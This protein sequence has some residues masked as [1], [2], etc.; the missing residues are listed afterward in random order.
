MHYLEVDFR[1]TPACHFCCICSASSSRLIN[2]AFWS[3]Q[4]PRRRVKYLLGSCWDSKTEA[5]VL[6]ACSGCRWEILRAAAL[7]LVRRCGSAHSNICAVITDQVEQDSS[8]KF[9]SHPS[10][11]SNTFLSAAYM[12]T[13]PKTRW[14]RREGRGDAPP[15]SAKLDSFRSTSD[16][17]N[18]THLWSGN[19]RNQNLE[20]SGLR[21]KRWDWI[22][23]CGS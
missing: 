15:P 6:S 17:R 12:A 9:L 20:W 11:Q 23:K 5:S 16:L 14:V 19:C 2:T 10:L 8:A 13:L 22:W 18:K 7:R 21:S 3:Q 4:R 1:S